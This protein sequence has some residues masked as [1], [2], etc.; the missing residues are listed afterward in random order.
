MDS[1]L[2][3]KEKKNIP[4]KIFYIYKGMNIYKSNNIIK[5]KYILVLIYSL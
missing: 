2:V 5:F 4:K 1:I 3:V